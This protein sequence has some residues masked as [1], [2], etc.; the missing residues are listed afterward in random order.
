[1]SQSDNWADRAFVETEAAA[2]LLSGVKMVGCSFPIWHLGVGGLPSIAVPRYTIHLD[3]GK[4]FF[5]DI[6]DMPCHAS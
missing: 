4:V 3:C 1:M 5:R 6:V 2:R